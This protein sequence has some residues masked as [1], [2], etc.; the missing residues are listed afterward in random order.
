MSKISVAIVGMGRMGKTRLDGM[1]RHGG[2]EAVGLCD[3][4][5]KNL[6]GYDVPTF[7]DYRECI[8]ECDP[9][10][11]V[12]CTYNAFIPDVVC[13]ALEGGRHVFSEKPP[14][15]SLADAVR[16]RDC[17]REHPECVLKFGFNH[18]YHNSVI[19]A[20]NL[21]DSGLL[22]ELVCAR[23]VY[24]KAG[25][26]TFSS[27]WRNDRSLSG[28]GIMIDQGIHM[29]DLLSY[30]L[31]GFTKV[32]SSVGNLVWD[33]ISTDDSAFAVLGNEQGKI[34]SLH[35]SALQWRHK[36]NLDLI[37][38]EGFVSLNG[39]KTSTSSY[40]RESVT[41]YKK[42]LGL[43]TGGLGKP[44]EHTMYFDSDESWD[45]EHR[46]F[47]GA[48]R[49]GRPIVNGTADEAVQI[50]SLIERIYSGG[51][52]WRANLRNPRRRRTWRTGTG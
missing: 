52:E 29:L 47:Y 34:A 42:D 27:E 6:Q 26:S 28:G 12:V 38:T 41:Y 35:S 46:E 31:G 17:S 4:A 20:K 1:T 3:T 43:K 24:G 15:R 30:F 39:L 37:C 21:V 13:Y 45:H 16:M 25:S 5:E 50:M 48:V 32:K 51:N 18:R 36:F 19:E 44:M 8:D 23:G 14:G 11:V 33:S 49:E 40:G 2:Y 9:E 7:T 22:G 10:A